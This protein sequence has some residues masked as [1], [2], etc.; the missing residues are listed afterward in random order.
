MWHSKAVWDGG[1]SVA[2]T[3][4]KISAGRQAEET[5]TKW[6]VAYLT[7]GSTAG[8]QEEG[9]AQGKPHRGEFLRSQTVSIPP[10]LPDPEHFPEVLRLYLGKSTSFVNEM[11]GRT[12]KAN[13]P[14]PVGHL[15]G[16]ES[17]DC[18]MRFAYASGWWAGTVCTGGAQPLFPP[19]KPSLCLL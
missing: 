16:A 8:I 10:P 3:I 15:H 11:M 12:N 14:Q 6:K 5:R 9:C 2:E 4:S 7:E 19:L 18:Q 17:Q 13:R 1:E